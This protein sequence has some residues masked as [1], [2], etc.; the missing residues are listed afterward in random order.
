MLAS[1][2]SDHPYRVMP[3][4]PQPARYR[5]APSILDLGDRFYDPVEAARFPETRLRFRNVR[6]AGT[7]GLVPRRDAQWIAPSRRFEPLPATL[8]AP[9]PC[10]Y[11]SHKSRHYT[12][13]HATGRALLLRH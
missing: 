5:P 9:P 3:A 8:P 12:P 13:D 10:R 4:F 6:A 7:V 1:F 2:A 11:P